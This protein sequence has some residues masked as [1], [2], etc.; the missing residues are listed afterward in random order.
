MCGSGWEVPQDVR[1]WSA[2]LPG[3]PGMVG[4]PPGC[5]GVFVSSR[6]ASQMSGIGLEAL[7][8]IGSGRK[9]PQMSGSG[10]EVLL[11]VR[12][13]SRGRPD[14][15]E[16]SGV[17]PGCLGMVGR[18]STMFRNGRESLPD[19]K[20]WSRG[21]PGSMGMVGRPSRK[22]GKSLEAILDVQVWSGAPP[23]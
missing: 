9:A 20:E 5:P 6:E 12:E 15:R 13:W 21:P 1:E 4:R 16:F 17:P 19:V 14:V 3:C 11:D 7:P 22:S 10:C 23:G 8:D 18:P 2:G